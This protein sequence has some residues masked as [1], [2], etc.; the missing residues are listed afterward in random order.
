MDL[1]ARIMPINLSKNSELC[2]KNWF[3]SKECL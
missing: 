2:P 1:E 3:I